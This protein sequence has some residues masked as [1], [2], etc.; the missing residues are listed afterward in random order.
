MYRLKLPETI[1]KSS[2]LS[3]DYKDDLPE[4]GENYNE[5]SKKQKK[6]I[7]ANEYK[8]RSEKLYK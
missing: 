5:L 3:F 1:F 6:A 7:Q 2:N 4:M 8:N